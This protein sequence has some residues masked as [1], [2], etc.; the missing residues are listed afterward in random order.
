[1]KTIWKLSSGRRAGQESE[2]VKREEAEKYIEKLQS[3][4]YKVT[5]TEHNNFL[6]IQYESSGD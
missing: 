5:V 2:D 6:E 1:M 4:G 3:E